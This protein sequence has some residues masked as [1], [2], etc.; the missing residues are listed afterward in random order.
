MPEKEPARLE[1]SAPNRQ[2]AVARK[3]ATAAMILILRRLHR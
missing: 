3:D 1:E 2:T